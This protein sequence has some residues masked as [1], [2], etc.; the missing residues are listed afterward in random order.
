MAE[1]LIE[2]RLLDGSADGR[3]ICELRNWTGMAWKIPRRLLGSSADLEELSRV[4][5]SILFGRDETANEIS[6]V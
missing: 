5:V 1:K 2:M 4:G 3:V 6:I